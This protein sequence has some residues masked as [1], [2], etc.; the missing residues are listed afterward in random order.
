[1][2]L[3]TASRLIPYRMRWAHRAFAGAFAYFWLP[4][5]LC[6]ACFG[7]HEWRDI[8]GNLSSIPDETTPGLSHGI[9]PA[10]TR[11]GRA[12]VE[13]RPATMLEPVTFAD[14]DDSARRVRFKPVGE[15]QDI[16]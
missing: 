12:G 2:A 13:W 10:C 7:G 1:M 14:D 9:C 15:D 8:D 4:C 5:P 6:G 16:W 3:E 11:A